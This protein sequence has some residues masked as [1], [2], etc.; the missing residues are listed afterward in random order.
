VSRVTV[1]DDILRVFGL[2]GER[3][4][5]SLRIDLVPNELPTVTIK[6]RITAGELDQLHTLVEVHRLRPELESS[7]LGTPLQ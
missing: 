1:N 6:K 7:E 4:V 5:T 2:A 3:Q